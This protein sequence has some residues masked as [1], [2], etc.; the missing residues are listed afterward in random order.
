MFKSNTPP[1]SIAYSYIAPLVRVLVLTAFL[2]T[3]M[4]TSTFA[5]GKSFVI[6]NNTDMYIP[7]VYYAP[8]GGQWKKLD[9]I[10]P[11]GA[12]GVPVNTNTR[13]RYFKIV[14]SSG[15]TFDYSADVT[16]KDYLTIP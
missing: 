2:V 11:G 13:I 8:A 12:V 5:A 1:K 15:K 16:R 7:A 14:F 3:A 4:Q 6:Y 10:T 9:G